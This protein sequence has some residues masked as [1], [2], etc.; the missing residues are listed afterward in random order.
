MKKLSFLVMVIGFALSLNGQVNNNY[1]KIKF[2][3]GQVDVKRS[4][5]VI[6]QAKINTKVYTGD[7]IVTGAHGAAQLLLRKGIQIRI[8]KNSVF[9]LKKNDVSADKKDTALSVSAGK[10]WLKIKN[11]LGKNDKFQVETPTAVVGVRG[12]IFVVQQDEAGTAVYVAKGAV[13]FLS[14][15]LGKE[16]LVEKDF[17]V[18]MDNDGNI[19]GVKAMSKSDK[20]NMMSGIPIFVNGENKDPGN[21]KDKDKIDLKEL[22]K[23]EINNEKRNIN[24]QRRTIANLK[25]ED[26]AAGRTLYALQFD[27]SGNI[28]GKE[29]VR[30]EQTFRKRGKNG[31]QLVN[32]TKRDEEI[33]YIDLTVKFDKDL[34]ENL[35]DMVDFFTE[36]DSDI[37]IVEKDVLVGAKRKSKLN[38]EIKW[39]STYDKNTDEWDDT[40]DITGKITKKGLKIKPDEIKDIEEGE[41]KLYKISELQLYESDGVTKYK[42][43]RIQMY[44]INNDGEILS[45]DHFENND[46]I[47]DLLNTTA[48]QILIKQ[49]DMLNGNINLVTTPDIAFVIIQDIL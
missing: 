3:M 38:D 4:D 32:L 28:I 20:Q 12:T 8:A 29:E 15:L 10:I 44:V 27:K 14:K 7:K 47:L 43:L 39:V 24:R 33:T 1:G 25:N 16:V 22:L 11:R 36:D 31:L 21:K 42:T 30:V 45:E 17:M 46:N 41:S 49:D 26:L 40:V 23:S 2:V 5:G 34:P 9:E 48:G 19:A 18:T 6:F 13:A 35:N 37:E